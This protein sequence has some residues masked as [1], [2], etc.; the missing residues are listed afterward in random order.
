MFRCLG[1]ANALVVGLT[2]VHAATLLM[3]KEQP[4][5]SFPRIA[6][7]G[8]RDLPPNAFL[9]AYCRLRLMRPCLQAPMSLAAIHCRK[10]SVHAVGSIPLVPAC[11]G[12]APSLSRSSRRVPSPRKL[13]A[14][15]RDIS[16]GVGLRW[17]CCL[18]LPFFWPSLIAEG[19]LALLAGVFSSCHLALEV[20]PDLL[21]LASCAAEEACGGPAELLEGCFAS[22]LW[23]RRRRRDGLGDDGCD[24]RRANL[25][26]VPGGTRHSGYLQMALMVCAV[27]LGG[28]A[29]RRMALAWWWCCGGCLL[30]GLWSCL[31]VGSQ[32]SFAAGGGMFAVARKRE[33]EA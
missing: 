12:G 2:D 15:S 16:L 28:A 33:R 17:R 11:V 9:H 22:S 30:R 27:D 8:A 7:P 14:F 5:S 10:S 21:E 31:W 18:T 4:S 23:W 25:V 32:G 3:P 20:M 19:A 1:L 24:S 13:C 6:R 26:G 29:E